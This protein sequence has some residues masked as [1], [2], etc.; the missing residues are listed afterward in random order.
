MPAFVEW[1]IAFLVLLEVVVLV[2]AL[3]I[4]RIVVD[5]AGIRKSFW[6]GGNT[7]FIP[8]QEIVE[9]SADEVIDDKTGLALWTFYRIVSPKSVFFLGI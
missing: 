8:Y 4:A 5:V 7:I 6:W 3:L 1:S 9:T 2:R